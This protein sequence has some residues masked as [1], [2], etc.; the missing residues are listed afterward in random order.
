MI[1]RGLIL[2]R[3]NISRLCCT[4][5]GLFLNDLQT[6]QLRFWSRTSKLTFARNNKIDTRSILSHISQLYMFDC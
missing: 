5:K 2:F 3:D 4:R 6:L 1:L